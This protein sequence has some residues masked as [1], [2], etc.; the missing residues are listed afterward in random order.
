MSAFMVSD[1]TIRVIAIT[2]TGS[3]GGGV[4]IPAANDA[5]RVLHA[6]NVNSLADRY[7]D[8]PNQGIGVAPE[9]SAGDVVRLGIIKPISVIKQAHCFDYQSCEWKEYRGSEAE[10]LMEAAIRISLGQIPG[11]D[12]APWGL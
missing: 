5:A 7:G 10:Q 4:N 8:N 3:H 2:A 12:D 11:Y 9:V 1:D 6:A